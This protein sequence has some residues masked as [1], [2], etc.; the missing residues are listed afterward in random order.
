M[1]IV[2]GPSGFIGKHLIESLLQDHP[3]VYAFSRKAIPEGLIGGKVKTIL[4]DITETIKLPPDVRTIYH[5]AGVLYR[6]DQ[7]VKVNVDGTKNIAEAALKQGCRLIHLSSAGV[8]GKYK[9]RVIDENS[10]CNPQNLYER[11]K[12]EAE[13]VIREFVERGLDARILRPTIVFGVK[14]G[15]REDGFLQ[16]LR[17]MVSDKYKSI[18]S[19]KGIYNIVHVDEVVR[20][21]RILDDDTIRNGETFFI[22]TPTTFEQISEI[23]TEEV[24]P[25]RVTS[26]DIPLVMAFSAAVCFSFLSLLAGRRIALTLPRLRVLINQNVF[27]QDLLESST[28]YRPL[29]SV[30]EYVRE[31]CRAYSKRRLLN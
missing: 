5:C 18:C 13:K 27:S 11:T 4:G 14:D 15:G 25:G 24:S 6:E 29:K 2:T 3:L 16:L 10:E 20:A 28:H 23:V 19:G 26:R 12:Y 30:E 8:V 1:I 21:M 17:S 31:V 9:T 22:N 7:M